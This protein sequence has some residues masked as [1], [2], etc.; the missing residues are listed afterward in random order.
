M[1]TQ[2]LLGQFQQF[3]SNPIASMMSRKMVIPQ[4]YMNDP[5]DA[6]Q[7]LMNTGRLSQEQ[8]N[9]FNKKAK[10][11]QKDPNFKKYMGIQ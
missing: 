4:Q 1:D 6:I 2:A 9:K 5:N 8:Y 7:Y 10:E 3:M 11:I